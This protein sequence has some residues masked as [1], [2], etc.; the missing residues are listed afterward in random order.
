M[1]M[2]ADNE[3]CTQLTGL[4]QVKTTNNKPADNEGALKTKFLAILC[5]SSN[6]DKE[7]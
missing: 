1:E 5:R 3:F 6:L 7:N 4:G 2:P